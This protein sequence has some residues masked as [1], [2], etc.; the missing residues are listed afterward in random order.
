[1]VRLIYF[2]LKKCF[3]KRAILFAM[4]AFSIINVAKISSVYE[5]NSLITK[6]SSPIWN[7]VYWQL[8]EEYSGK[9]TP[10][11]IKSLLSVYKPL[12]QKTTDLTASTR[13]DDLNTYT[14]NVYSD[15]YLLSWYYVKPMEYTYMYTSTAADIATKA[16]E[17]MEFFKG[18]GNDYLFRENRAIAELYAGREVSE[19]SYTEMYQYYVEYDFSSLLVLLICLY[20]L[21]GVFASEKESDMD[22]LLLTTV[23]G[24]KR[25]VT[26]KIIAS[27]LFILAIASWFWVLDFVAFGVV[28][29]SFEAG[30]IPLYALKNFENTPLN[31]SLFGYAV[32]SAA[33]KIGGMMVLGLIFLALSSVSKNA[34]LPFISNLGVAGIVILF[35]E[36]T[37]GSGNILAKII[38]PFILISNSE[39]FGKTEFMNFAGI[40]VLS[41]TAA[42]LFAAILGVG[43]CCLIFFSTKT[44]TLRIRRRA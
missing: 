18:K 4:L 11:R 39:L 36:I 34:L 7:E 2:E 16:Q 13:M 43:V 28:F 9:M 14:G 22:T 3:F 20:G 21:V 1:M 23:N 26:A 41:Y 17:N 8:Y 40:P 32:L 25:T 35:G 37:A 30:S 5:D 15:Y 33:I 27:M 24:G 31:I 44:N 10:E 19:F 6:R 38:N 12:E 42:I 29:R